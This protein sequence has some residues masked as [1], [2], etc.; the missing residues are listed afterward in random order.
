[1]RW[2]VLLHPNVVPLLGIVLRNRDPVMVWEWMANGNIMEFI[3]SHGDANR[4]KLVGVSLLLPTASVA[5]DP[6]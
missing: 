3:K 5:Y 2:R 6:R 1:M 4:F